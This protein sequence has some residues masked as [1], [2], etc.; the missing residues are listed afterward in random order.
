MTR[1]I[2]EVACVSLLYDTLAGA[3]S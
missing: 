2:I 1:S 3:L